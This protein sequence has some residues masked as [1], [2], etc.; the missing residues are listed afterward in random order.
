MKH[1]QV[2]MGIKAEREHWRTIKYLEDYVKRRK[3]FPKRKK[4]Y[5]KI[6]E[7]H[8]QEDPRYYSKLKK[9]KL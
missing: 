7:D 5:E 2:S 4:I 9:C 3:T 8:L 6:V 1:S